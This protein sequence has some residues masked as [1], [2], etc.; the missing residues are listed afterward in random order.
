MSVISSPGRVAEGVGT[1]KEGW[2]SVVA[3]WNGQLTPVYHPSPVKV[4]KDRQMV[5]LEEE[6]QVR[7]W[8]RWVPPKKCTVGLGEPGG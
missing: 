3:G 2:A 4:D 8:D 6:F 1:N 5:V 7:I